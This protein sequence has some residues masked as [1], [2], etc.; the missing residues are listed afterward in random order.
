MRWREEYKRKQVS[1]EEA[2]KAVKS[3]DWVYIPIGQRLELLAEALWARRDELRGVKIVQGANPPNYPWYQAGYEDSF[4]VVGD[5]YSGPLFRPL[6]WERRGDFCPVG[7]AMTFKG[8]DDRRPGAP[9]PDVTFVVVSPPDEHGFCSFGDSLFHKKDLVKRSRTVVAEVNSLL[10]RTYGDNFVHVSEI[11][12]FVEATPYVPSQ[13]EI[14]ALMAQM[15]P[16]YRAELEP[17]MKEMGTPPHVLWKFRDALPYLSQYPISYIKGVLGM[18]DIPEHCYAIRDYLRTLINDGDTIQIGTGNTSNPTVRAGLFDG[19][20]DLGLHSEVIPPGVI[21]LV[22]EGIFTGK[23]K[24]IHQGKVVTPSY[25]PATS[26]NQYDSEYVNENPLF[27]LYSLSYCNNVRT[28]SAHDN[29]VSIQNAMFVD[30]TG[31]IGSETRPGFLLENGPGGTLDWVIGALNSK[32]G[33]S[34]FVLPSTAMGAGVSRIVPMI[35]EE[36]MVTVPRAYADFIVTE[37]GIASLMGKSQR[38]RAEELISIA[39]P[40]FRA[41]LRKE[42]QRLFGP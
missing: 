2:V 41:E 15:P 27:E 29:M 35:P 42:A 38:Q 16:D 37:Y 39:H 23:Y 32:G 33:R 8:M 6:Q 31:Q 24:T 22:K 11:D 5:Q 21:P 17:A 40:D 14:D 4:L 12:Y 25:W 3:G 13:E 26:F 20:H 19:M 7:Y 18:G 30:L 28:I 10:I 34:I 36:V 1:A 9:Q